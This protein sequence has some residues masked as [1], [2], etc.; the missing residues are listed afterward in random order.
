VKTSYKK[1]ALKE[2]ALIP[3]EFR[4]P[5]EIFIFEVL[6]ELNNI[7]ES[8]KIEPLKGYHNFFKVRFGNYR[9]GLKREGEYIVVERI[10]HR[11]E[12]YKYFP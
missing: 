9:I 11:K 7:L 2:L 1:K 3:S 4:S 8:K 5:I 10:L 6:P 12:I